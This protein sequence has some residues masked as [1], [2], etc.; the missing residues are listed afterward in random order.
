MDIDEPYDNNNYS[1][2]HGVPNEGQDNTHA[3][4]FHED[5]MIDNDA[6]GQAPR[7]EDDDDDEEVGLENTDS[8]NTTN[9]PKSSK[10]DSTKQDHQTS[11]G[12]GQNN[13][14]SADAE[15]DWYVQEDNNEED[16]IALKKA[17]INERNSPEILPYAGTVLE[18][19]MEL[20]SF[21]QEA[22]N[23]L[24][25][26]GDPKSG[27]KTIILLTDLERIKYI[28]R[29]YL[30]ARLSKLE[31]HAQFYLSDL[32]YRNRM[33]QQ[34]IDY[35]S[36]H[37]QALESH[38]V[39]SFLNQFPRHLKS[40][41]VTEQDAEEDGDESAALSGAS[42]LT[43]PDLNEAVFCRVKEEIGDYQFGDA[44]DI[45]YMARNSIFITK[46]STVR[47]LLEDGKVDLI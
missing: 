18:N 26:Q 40:S 24:R 27:F 13:T 5:D 28:V 2:S 12:Q 7:M 47:H 31:T 37:V 44:Q 45:I 38:Y 15:V 25:E 35:L 3:H 8:L 9:K 4:Q 20:M 46:Y 10:G 14:S 42:M 19:L 43:K 30:R 23:E 41:I 29:S 33:S 34:E 17:W 22:I 16:W 11:E 36:R 21:Q 32:A 39:D 1:S 6:F